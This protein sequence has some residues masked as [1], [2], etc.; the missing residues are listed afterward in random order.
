MHGVKLDWSEIARTVLKQGPAWVLLGYAVWWGTHRAEA[1]MTRV[2]ALLQ[3]NATV[4]AQQITL[5]TQLTTLMGQ[6]LEGTTRYQRA[7]LQLQTENCLNQANT[8]ATAKKCR[9]ILLDAE[10]GR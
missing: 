1:Q 4:A 5:A 10:F 7:M 3:E 2:E 8:S 6:H 9:D